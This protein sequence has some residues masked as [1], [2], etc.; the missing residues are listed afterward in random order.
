MDDLLRRNPALLPALALLIG[1]AVGPRLVVLPLAL[2]ALLLAAA[3]ALGG[4]G[5]VAVGALAVGLGLGWLGGAQGLPASIDPARPVSVVGEVVAPASC[6]DDGRTVV[7]LRLISLRQGLLV[8]RSRLDLWLTVDG[9]ETPPV[10]GSRWRAKGL[11]GRS[12]GYRNDP[13]VP[14][15]AWRL[16]LVSRRF[17][18]PEAPPS[19]LARWLDTVRRRGLASIR[20]GDGEGVGGP[21]LLAALLL[22]DRGNLDLRVVQGLR[23]AG[24]AHLL[25]VSGLHVGVLAALAWFLARPLPRPAM[26]LWVAIVVAAYLALL[27]PRPSIL[28]SA[29]MALLALAALGLERPPQGLNALAVAVMT[30]VVSEPSVVERLGFQ[31][32]VAATAGIVVLAP[33]LASALPLPEQIGRW[34]AVP[35][36]A[37]LSTLPWILPLT[38]GFHPL[39]PMLDLL[40]IPWLATYLGAGVVALGAA[41]LGA[42]TPLVWMA[43]LDHPVLVLADLPASPW[44]FCPLRAPWWLV[45]VVV[46]SG[47]VLALRRRPLG[48]EPWHGLGGLEPVGGGWGR[49]VARCVRVVAL[50]ALALVQAGARAKVAEPPGLVAFDVGQGDA[51]LLRDGTEAVLVDGGGWRRGDFGGR[52]LVPALVAVGVDRLR[53]VVLTHPDRDHCAGLRDVARYLVVEEVWMGPGWEEA[54]AIELTALARRGWS[55]L[56][57]GDRRRVGRWRLEVLHP[58]AGARGG[59]NDRSLVIRARVTGRGILLTGDL[60]ARGEAELLRRSGPQGGA[61]RSV[62]LK[63]GHHGS[64]TS[65]TSSFLIGV[66]PRFALI[67]AGRGN[68]YGH[69]TETVLRRLARHVVAVLR[70]DREGEIRWTLPALPPSADPEGRDML[71][72]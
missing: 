7:P 40:A 36:A 25:A 49:G 9:C 42:S 34:L 4:R 18:T 48:C 50:V 71:S 26:L 53:A 15:G 35:L 17:L 1:A 30:M 43:C 14:P 23:R 67:S 11:L 70:T 38:G 59:R 12:P 20:G 29:S 44:L 63:V 13:E 46:G 32:S 45:W 52:V 5:G 56:W 62:W 64:K 27:G 65:T 68:P 24:L 61:L 66:A 28:R 54:C 51:L 37:Q 57:G 10:P 22:G 58:L 33:W 39:A 60:E 41:A 31:L 6:D 69:P 55:P 72:P 16:P 2:L 3:S 19:P 47:L 21:R 8:E